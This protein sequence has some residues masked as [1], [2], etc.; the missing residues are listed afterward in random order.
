MTYVLIIASIMLV[1]FGLV[2]AIVPGIAGPPFSFLGVLALSFVEGVFHSTEFLVI[3]GVIGAIIFLL[4]YVVPVWGTKT[5]GGT[6]AG[7]RGSTIGLILGL[8]VTIVFPIGFIAILLGPFIGA[9]IGEK[10]AGTD[11][12]LAW[13]SAFGSFLGFL[14]GTFIKV[15]YASVCIF[16]VIKDLIGLI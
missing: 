14:A 15:V 13:R 9:Y 4:D 3:L 16:F 10:N 6:K 2:G 1:L 5:M 11:D 7:T 12:H 8:L